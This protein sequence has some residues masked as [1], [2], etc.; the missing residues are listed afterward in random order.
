MKVVAGTDVERDE[1]SSPSSLEKAGIGVQYTKHCF[2]KFNFLKWKW[3][4]YVEITEHR[5]FLHRIEEEGY[6][7]YPALVWVEEVRE[8]LPKPKLI[9]ENLFR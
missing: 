2:R 6:L 7:G 5:F 1:W 9:V 8:E 4:Y 3:V